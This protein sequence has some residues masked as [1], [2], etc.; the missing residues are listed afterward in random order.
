MLW[1]VFI[2]SLLPISEL[3]G[4]IP[5]GFTAGDP[6]FL[7]IIIAILGNILVIPLVYFF[8]NKFHHL[9]MNNVS[10]NKLFNKYIDRTRKKIEHKI[11]TKAEFTAI[12]LFTAVPFPLTGAYTASVISWFFG[13][14]RA[15]A[16]CAI[17]L[18]VLIAAIIV[19]LITLGVVSVS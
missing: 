16:F 5:Y 18:G 19:S 9:F 6:F 12:L 7:V 17:S 4:A 11:G 1:K 15:K 3:R 14:N 8:M 10:Y 13:L 2:L